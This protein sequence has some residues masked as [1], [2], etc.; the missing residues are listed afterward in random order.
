[1]K[2]VLPC[3]IRQLLPLCILAS[4]VLSTIPSVA[5]AGKPEVT[6]AAASCDQNRLCRFDV[7]VRHDDEGWDHYA[8]RF[9]LE[10]PTGEVLGT[11]VL[12]HPH[13]DEQPFTR[14]LDRVSIAKNLTEVHVFAYDSVHGRSEEPFIVKLE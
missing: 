2:I 12:H 10:S 5:Y 7:T 1:M 3:N 14:S 13:V 11:R 4:A 8:N 6:K 9:E